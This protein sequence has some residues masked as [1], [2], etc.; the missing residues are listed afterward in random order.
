VGYTGTDEWY[1]VEGS[2]LESNGAG[3][4]SPSELRR[5]HERIVGHLTKPGPTADGSKEPVS[6]LAFCHNRSRAVR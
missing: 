3:G 5:L 6:S 4:S 2:V 1:T